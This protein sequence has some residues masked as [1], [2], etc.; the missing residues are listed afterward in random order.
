MQVGTAECPGR[1]GQEA[2]ALK[3][4]RE[5]TSKMCHCNSEC[6]GGA[7]STGG[8][9]TAGGGRLCW[10]VLAGQVG[11]GQACT[12]AAWRGAGSL[13]ADARARAVGWQACH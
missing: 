7:V 8:R 11:L 6:L 1:A 12:P 5:K 13:S 10:T 2:I 3:R 9:C 4:I